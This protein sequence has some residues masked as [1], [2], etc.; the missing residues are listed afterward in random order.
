MK[1]RFSLLL[2][3]AAAAAGIAPAAELAL[4]KLDL[5]T[6]T[7]G[8]NDPKAGK[9]IE[10]HPLTIAG[11]VYED[12]IGTH[13]DSEF[14]LLLDGKA[15]EFLAEV[16]VDDETNARGSVEFLL[17]ADGKTIFK[18]GIVTGGHPAQPVKVPLTGVRK[19]TLAVTSGEDGIDYDHADWAIARI[20]FSGAA[21]EVV[22]HAPEVAEILTPKPGPK[23]RL[24]GPRIFGAR[25]GNPFQ[26]RITAT[27]EK[28]VIFGAQ[29]LPDG[30]KINAET[31]LITGSL[32][33]KG[34]WKVIV[35]AK[36]HLGEAKRELTITA[37]DR[38]SLTPPMGWN[39]WNCFASAVTD[40][41]IRDAAKVMAES[42][43]VDHGWSY[44][45]IDDF[46]QVHPGSNDKSLQGTERDAEGRILPNPRFPDMK[47]LTGYIHSLGLKAGI[48]SSPG[49]LTCG[50]CS[51]SFGHELSDAATYADW[52]FDY[53]KYDWCSYRPQL[54]GTRKDGPIPT[55][56]IN[57]ITNDSLLRKMIPYAVMSDALRQQKRDIHF[58]LCQYGDGNVSSWGDQVGGNSWRT[59]GDIV[60]T[61]GSMSK[62]GFGQAGL[63]KFARAGNW[64]DP[65]ML[66]VGM[67]G[68]GPSLHQTRLTPNEQYTHITLW[69]LLASPLLIGCDLTKLDEF[70]T[71]LLT[72]DEVIE[73]NQDPLG[74]Q[75]GRISKDGN[76]EMWAKPMSDGSWAV[77][78]FNRG[79]EAAPVTLDPSLIGLSGGVRV[80]D[81]WRQ[82]DRP[83]FN[84]KTTLE[85]PRHG[86][87]LL[88]VSAGG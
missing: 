70:T 9:T 87:A 40:R 33:A 65:D 82:K 6:M 29:G 55:P 72:N 88:R 35:S 39:S 86:C 74:R 27:G 51:G 3:S 79:P 11:K 34:E 73:V 25:P 78:L 64:N 83:S 61:W 54:E 68:W 28:P 16:G 26:H 38:I 18:S 48:Y 50:G 43:L 2:L 17:T 46:W 71:N 41:H 52:G 22:R 36:N 30:L 85:I 60:D 63:E 47:G 69:S 23:P 4:S 5:S 81:L 66:V 10:G 59:T 1:T 56:A 44:I 20:H 77:G 76:A 80:R 7:S 12:G 62:I 15:D 75:A 67:V 24:T 8:F 37:G 49:P 58:S 21:P 31:G 32:A 45:N 42:S 14:T 53:L 84:G 57:S 19:L 13:A